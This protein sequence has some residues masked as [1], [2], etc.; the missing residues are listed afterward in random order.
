[1]GFLVPTRSANRMLA[2][3]LN[4]EATADLVL[5][6][7]ENDVTPTPGDTAARY[8][9]PWQ[10]TP[11]LLGGLD[12]A[13]DDARA[14]APPQVFEFTDFR[15]LVYGYFVVA[16]TTGD[17]MWAERFTDGPYRIQNKGD[18]ITVTPNLSLTQ[19]E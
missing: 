4:A 9:E 16:E 15:G 17:L 14:D 1:M 19:I 8:T 13:I 18:K 7:Y 3:I 5:K 2:H 6:L 12:W 11:H 10:Y